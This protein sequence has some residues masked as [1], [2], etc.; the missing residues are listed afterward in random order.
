LAEILSDKL[1]K[2]I[3]LDVQKPKLEI[4]NLKLE[5]FQGSH[6]L[7]SEQNIQATQEI[8][9]L[10]EGLGEGDLLINFICGGGSA[11][12]CASEEEL[13]DASI[14]FQ[15]L[16]K[17]GA[18]IT[19]LNA[20][21]KHLSKIKGGGLAKMACRAQVVSLVVSDVCGNDLSMV[22]SGPTVF[23]KTTKEDA[24]D[25]L[26]KYG[27]DTEDFHLYE[28]PKEQE[29]FKNVRNI[30][31]VCNQDAVMAMAE[32]AR[33]LGFEAKIYSL[34]L[35]GEAMDVFTDI[36]EGIEPG[37]T[38]LAAGEA[39]V[40]LEGRP[41]GKG[42]RNMEA[43]LGEVARCQIPDDR[44]RNSVI[45]SFTSD[46]RDNT[47]AAG[48][49]GDLLTLQNAKKIGLIPQG[50]LR[51]NQS[52]IFFDKVGDLMYVEQRCFNVADLMIVLKGK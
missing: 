29:C 13:K 37:Q 32:K 36:N 33:E 5:I 4:R 14:I 45:M 25:I 7:P 41:Q 24:E 12:A 48:A 15:K 50:M 3:A 38:I 44:C 47:E 10:A 39:T 27:L 22:S 42:G 34:A 21:R 26:K 52:F 30:L 43:V 8:I 23:D 18:T 2:G 51:Q 31:F 9:K 28:T 49:I 6:P 11:L 17:V 40:T 35:Q 20:V 1:T 16:T 46:G 19:E